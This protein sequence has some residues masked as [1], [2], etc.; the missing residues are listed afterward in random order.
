MGKG[1]VTSINIS[2]NENGCN[3]TVGYETPDKQAYDQK[4]YTQKTYNADA[5]LISQI[6]NYIEAD[7]GEDV[8][9][10][11]VEVK[12]L[13]PQTFLTKAG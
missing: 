6:L 4:R 3:V 1:K 12:K 11:E 7:L 5:E 13:N 2:A 9:E 8:G 10:T